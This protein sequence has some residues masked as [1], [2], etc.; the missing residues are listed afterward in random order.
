MRHRSEIRHAVRRLVLEPGFTIVSVLVLAIG[1]GASTA[2]FSIVHAV[3]LQP[4]GVDAPDRVVVGWPEY[5]V[6]SVSFR[7]TR[8]EIGS[9]ESRLST[10]WRCSDR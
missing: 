4:I 3:L 7:S 2:M 5:R 9:A 6:S 8:R 1:V 10:Q